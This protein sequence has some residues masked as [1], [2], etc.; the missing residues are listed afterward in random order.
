MS[1]VH[2]FSDETTSSELDVFKTPST[3]TSVESRRYFSHKPTAALTSSNWIDFRIPSTNGYV[4]LSTMYLDV[5]LAITKA[6]GSAL[7]NA[8]VAAAAQGQAAEAQNLYDKITPVN[9]LLSSLF[10]QV[11]VCLNNTLVTSATNLYHYRA[12]LD[13]LFY[14]S[15][16]AQD[17]Y[18]YSCLFDMD[19]N[20]RKERIKRCF[21]GKKLKLTGPLHLDLCQ[22]ERLLIS[23]VDVSIRLNIADSSFVFI[24]DPTTA[25]RPKFQIVD[26]TL[27]V[28]SKWLFPD[29]DAGIL[30]TLAQHDCLY[31]YNST[32]LRHYVIDQGSTTWYLDNIYPSILPRRFVIGI[33]K[34]KAFN[35]DFQEDPFNFQPYNLTEIKIFVNNVQVPT[36]AV[37][38]D[39][40]DDDFARSYFLFYENFRSLHPVTTL[41]ITP[42]DYKRNC[43][44]YCF[45]LS[46]E[47]TVD[48]NDST[49]LI[50]RGH[51]RVDLRFKSPTTE[52]LTAIVYSHFA[53]RMTINAERQAMIHEL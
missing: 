36:P 3:D 47:G 35:G 37:I 16:K 27:H 7:P 12:Y 49:A 24:V 13:C 10:Q 52:P 17:T 21:D 14:Q 4:D 9:N 45:H 1:L 15:K 53:Q 18:L 33:V 38:H 5:E 41:S 48:T 42:D 20:K 40:D 25:Q 50:Y 34:S 6:D 23:H 43:T 51:V 39:F 26:A 2:P 44:F 32:Q 19:S 29:V 46:N 8:Q 28:E 22:Q 30:S 31:F 11:D